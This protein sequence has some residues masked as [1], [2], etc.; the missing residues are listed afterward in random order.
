MEINGKGND[1]RIMCGLDEVKE[2]YLA[3]FKAMDIRSGDVDNSDALM[4]LQVYL[5]AEATKAGVNLANHMEWERF[6]GKPEVE[7]R[8]CE[9]RYADYPFGASSA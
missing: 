1:V 8:P 6:L 5:Y 7:I 4:D 2:I 9:V 3:L